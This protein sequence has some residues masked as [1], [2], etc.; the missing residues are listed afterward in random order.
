MKV[1]LRIFILLAFALSSALSSKA[2]FF[3]SNNAPYNNAFYLVN[4]V[5]AGGNVTISNLNFYGHTT[6]IGFFGNGASTIGMDSGIVL[7]TGPLRDQC[8]TCTTTTTTTGIPLLI[9][10]SG[11]AGPTWMSTTLLNISQSVPGL[12]GYT[13]A[14]T[15]SSAN[16]AAVIDFDF[17]PTKD[18]MQFRFVFASDEWTTYPCSSFNDMFSFLV[19]GP[20]LTGAFPSP[21][22]YTGGNQN[23]AFVPGT[24]IPISITSIHNGTGST[25][26]NQAPSYNQY[27]VTTPAGSSFSMNA[28]TTVMEITFPVQR[29]QTYHFTMGIADGS[30]RALTS[31]V[32]ME[33]NSFDA[34]GITISAAPSY[35]SLGGD[36]IL[37]EGCG[38]VD[39][40][41]V[42]H[43]S[44]HLADTVQIGIGGNA[45]NG[46]DYTFIPDSL[47]FGIGQ[48]SVT[49][50][51]SILPDFITEAE[52]LFIWIS[53]TNV[54]LGCGN[55][56]DS[57][58][59]ILS[60]PIPLLLDASHDTIMCTQ[61]NTQV[62][63]GAYQGFPEYNYIWST[64]DT[65]SA[66]IPSPFPTQDTFYVVT[67]TDACGVFTESDTAFIT[68][69]NPPTSIS[70]PDDTINC[71]T[72]NA[73]V[74][75]NIQDP[76]PQ[77]QINWSNGY[78]FQSFYVNNPY[79]TTDYI[80][81]V[82]QACAG[83][84]LVDT[85][86]LV[87]D[88][89]P[90]H[91]DVNDDTIA[92]I[93]GPVTLFANP[94]YTTPN[95]DFLWNNGS[96]N[97]FIT[98]KPAQTTQYVVAVTDACG[99]NT[100]YDTGTV[101]VIND[102]FWITG[103]NKSVPCVGDTA[104]ITADFHGGF[105]PYF[106][107]W[108]TNPGTWNNNGS[109]TSSID[110]STDSTTTY[111]ISLT[112]QCGQDTVTKTFTLVVATYD[113]LVI[114]PVDNDTVTCSGDVFEVRN[115]NVMGGSG[116]HLVSWDNWATNHDFL[117]GHVTQTTTY[118]IQAYDN[119]TQDS[120]FGTYTVV[121]PD[122]DPLEVD[123][124]PGDTLACPNE[125]IRI[126]A[127]P[128]GG[129]GEYQYQWNNDKKD[130]S[131]FSRHYTKQTW[132]VTVVDQCG[133]V[134]NNLVTIDRAAPTASFVHDELNAIQVMFQN[135]STGANQYLWDFGD[136]TTSVDENPWHEYLAAGMYPVMLVAIN[137]AGCTDT[138][139]SQVEAPL[140][141]FL[142]NAFTP[143]GDGLNDTWKV[144]GEGFKNNGYTKEFHIQVFDRWGNTV[145]E[146]HDINFEWDGMRGGSMVQMG[147]YPYK[148][149]LE[150]FDR[151]VFEQEGTVTIP[152]H[153]KK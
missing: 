53:D 20:G 73:I 101:H 8:N 150:G 138:A 146:S 50:N 48:D 7:S 136:S 27:Y 23:V 45:T 106:Y 35:T 41:F 56:G 109:A 76:M 104:T 31:A 9:G 70:C 132:Q 65:D 121:V 128:S 85:F 18:T 72:N 75:V 147:V 33:A 30:D 102:P 79:V 28:H 61:T 142:P 57:L 140:I 51:F 117:V 120:A 60:D 153:D 3:A 6:Q 64:G 78:A 149:R 38:S 17:I 42:R 71:E 125:F 119:C 111:T 123:I 46:V 83:Y 82:T 97:Q 62:H 44:I 21:P 14:G 133:E 66:F 141:A 5:F 43:D 77:L 131:F 96:T 13:G 34:T 126:S 36:S 47:V 122:Y 143:N 19:A 116:D 16:D 124:I 22:G 145:F 49:L 29:C 113:P 110:V 105:P 24:N 12:L 107:S 81:T 95:M 52:T 112:D 10:T 69:D 80:V 135:N 4:D 40:H 88:N 118:P 86:T 144:Y 63:A 151:Q 127:H 67:V 129:A 99:I 137:E 59:L 26:C 39:V 37:Y 130:S 134:A 55:S 87:V 68:I 91:L 139:W 103:D 108:S 25:P 74:S 114:L 32:Y 152:Y 89:P 2:Q 92:C 1:V 93:D 98:V 115:A 11:Y 90:I 148:V 58:M 94:S 84:T 100:Y 15:P 54:S